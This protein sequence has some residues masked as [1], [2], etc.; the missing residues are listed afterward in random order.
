M[1]YMKVPQNPL[2]TMYSDEAVT[3][4]VSSFLENCPNHQTLPGRKWK[5]KKKTV[6]II[7]SVLYQHEATNWAL[8]TLTLLTTTDCLETI[9]RLNIMAVQGTFCPFKRKSKDEI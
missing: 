2:D 5:K 3:C 9:W 8:K 1:K 6:S 4:N 7:F